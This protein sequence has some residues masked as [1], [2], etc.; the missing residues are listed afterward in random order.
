MRRIGTP[1]ETTADGKTGLG[2]F[3]AV[4]RAFPL[5][6]V[7]RAAAS[8]RRKYGG[9]LPPSCAGFKRVWSSAGRRPRCSAAFQKY[10]ED[11]PHRMAK[12]YSGSTGKTYSIRWWPKTLWCSI[13]GHVTSLT[14]GEEGLRSSSSPPALR[15]ARGGFDCW[16]VTQTGCA[17]FRSVRWIPPPHP[18][19][20]ASAA[21]P[22]DIPASP[23]PASR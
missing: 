14:R 12:I 7:C 17:G 10:G 11:I 21:V 5:R 3:A 13:W 18:R 15:R 1:G 20:A 23:R 19:A 4:R 22:A 8:F 2:R 9:F 6:D 16:R